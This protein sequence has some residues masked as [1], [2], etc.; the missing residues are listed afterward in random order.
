[1]KTDS[2]LIKIMPAYYNHYYWSLLQNKRKII[3]K[4]G[5]SIKIKSFYTPPKS[6]TLKKKITNKC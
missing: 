2:Q 3:Q 5:S 1:M 6:K 4:I